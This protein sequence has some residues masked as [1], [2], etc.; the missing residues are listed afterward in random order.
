MNSSVHNANHLRNRSDANNFSYARLNNEERQDLSFDEGL[1]PNL[2]SKGISVEN[3]AGSKSCITLLP[4]FNKESIY[5]QKCL[6]SPE[7]CEYG[8]SFSLWVYF[9][10]SSFSAKE[11]LL[12][13]TP[14]NCQGYQIRIEG[15]SLI[16]QVTGRSR[17]WS[18]RVIIDKDRKYWINYGFIWASSTGQMKIYENNVLLSS[19]NSDLTLSMSPS[20]AE[21]G[22]GLMLGCTT[23]HGEPEGVV[24]NMTFYSLALWYWPVQSP[25]FLNGGLDFYLYVPVTPTISTTSAPV[26]IRSGPLYPA[27]LTEYSNSANSDNS[28]TIYKTADFYADPSTVSNTLPLTDVATNTSHILM[29]DYFLLKSAQASGKIA[30]F[31]SDTCP[32]NLTACLNGFS[33]SFWL[34][35]PEG[36]DDNKLTVFEVTK[37][38]CVT[39]FGHS[40]YIFFFGASSSSFG[41]RITS[42]VP[43]NAWINVGFVTND[44]SFSEFFAYFNGQPTQ[45]IRVV[46]VADGSP[47][48]SGIVNGDLVLGSASASNL[49]VAK[50][51]VTSLC[52]WYQKLQSTQ[53]GLLMGYTAHQQTWLQNSDYFWTTDP[54]INQD[55]KAQIDT[56]PLLLRNRFSLASL[57]VPNDANLRISGA[58]HDDTYGVPILD[59]KSSGYFMLGKRKSSKPSW[60]VL[61]WTNDCLLDPTPLSCSRNG[62][63]LSIWVKIVT[64]SQT[65]TRFLLNSGNFGQESGVFQADFRGISVFTSGSLLGVSVSTQNLQWT[66]II[67][68]TVYKLRSWHNFGITW[69][70]SEGLC[71]YIDG[72]DYGLRKTIADNVYKS[73]NA[74]PYL[75]VGRYDSDE[76][77]TWLSPN[78]A[79]QLAKSN[80]NPLK[81]PNWEMANIQLGEMAYVKKHMSYLSYVKLFRVMGNKFL[82]KNEPKFYSWLGENLLVP[83]SYQLMTSKK[84]KSRPGQVNLSPTK[85]KAEWQED[86]F[87]VRLF[88]STGLLLGPV[89]N[90]PCLNS[91]ISCGDGFFIS[92]WFSLSTTTPEGAN[93]NNFTQLLRGASGRMGLAFSPYKNS[94][95]GWYTPQ[96]TI[97]QDGSV[98]LGS[99]YWLCLYALDV[100]K[101]KRF[102]QWFHIGLNFMNQKLDLFYNGNKVKSCDRN[103]MASSEPSYEPLMRSI[104]SLNK[105]IFAPQYV[106][107]TS[108]QQ[109]NP[110]ESI[111][112]SL[113]TFKSIGIGNSVDVLQHMGLDNMQMTIF[114]NSEF[115][116]PMSGQYQM[117]NSNR[118]RLFGS[119]TQ[120]QDKNGN[121]GGALCTKNQA[122]S[123]LQLSGDPLINSGGLSNLHKMCIIDSTG[124]SSF[125]VGLTFKLMSTPTS[126][127]VLLST[128]PDDAANNTIGFRLKLDSKAQVLKAEIFSRKNYCSNQ[129]STNASVAGSIKLSQWT[130]LLVSWYSGKSPNIYSNS[131]MIA[132]TISGSCQALDSAYYNY[133]TNGLVYPNLII[134]KGADGCFSNV[135][136]QD[137]IL[138]NSTE[139][140]HNS[141]T[142]CYPKA[143]GVL[144]FLGQVED[145]ATNLSSLFVNGTGSTSRE[146]SCLFSLDCANEGLTLSFWIK[147]F[148][149]VSLSSDGITI[150]NAGGVPTHSGVRI[151]LTPNKDD[152]ESLDLRIQVCT[153]K[154]LWSLNGP[155]SIYWDQWTNVG[156]TFKSL[157]STDGSIL[158]LYINGERTY[159]TSKLKPGTSGC[160][161]ESSVQRQLVLGAADMPFDAAIYQL[162]WWNSKVV[163]CTQMRN[164][165]KLLT[166]SCDIDESVPELKICIDLNKC[167]IASG[168]ICLDPTLDNIQSMASNAAVLNS[169]DDLG[170]LV[171]S[172][173]QL[174]QNV[175]LDNSTSTKNDTLLAALVSSASIKTQ[176]EKMTLDR[177]PTVSPVELAKYIVAYVDALQ[178]PELNPLWSQ[179]R[180]LTKTTSDS[181]ISGAS[182]ILNSLLIGSCQNISFNSSHVAVASFPVFSNV[183]LPN[184]SH[185]S[186]QKILPGMKLTKQE[187]SM[188]IYNFR[189]YSSGESQVN[190]P[191]NIFLQDNDTC[192]GFSVLLLPPTNSSTDPFVAGGIPTS[193][194]DL[195]S[196]QSVAQVAYPN[197]RN[198]N[199]QHI[200]ATKPKELVISSSVI[201]IEPRRMNSTRI[202]LN[203]STT[204]I[205]FTLPLKPPNIPKAIDNYVSYYRKKWDALNISVQMQ[206]AMKNGTKID[207]DLALPVQCVFWKQHSFNST[208]VWA[209]DGCYLVRANISHVTCTC[210]H[211][212]VFAIAMEP[213][214]SIRRPLPFWELNGIFDYSQHELLRFNINMAGNSLS[215]VMTLTTIGLFVLKNCKSMHKVRYQVRINF[216]L[217]L[218]LWHILSIVTPLL[219]ADLLHCQI[220]SVVWS[221]SF[222][223]IHSWLCRESIYLFYAY[224]EGKFDNYLLNHICWGWG[225]PL[226]FT[227][228]SGAVTKLAP[229]ADDIMCWLARESPVMWATLGFVCLLIVIAFLLTSI[230]SCN[231]ETPAY[232]DPHLIL[233][234]QFQM[235]QLWK[236]VVYESV[237]FIMTCLILYTPFIYSIYIYWILAS[238]QG[239]VAVIYFAIHDEELWLM[240]F[241]KKWDRYSENDQLNSVTKKLL[242]KFVNDEEMLEVGQDEIYL[243]SIFSNKTG[244]EL[245]D[246]ENFEEPLNEIFYQR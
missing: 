26:V 116:W 191:P 17:I 12:S 56:F 40:I 11:Y 100:Y 39:I 189:P 176:L 64:V 185:L 139:L 92:G 57:Y 203:D 190:L 137:D 74:P 192:N 19:A 14:T 188:A 93:P 152:S 144:R 42:S 6:E 173:A 46:S 55:A 106:A 23:S 62:F 5:Y 206:E 127:L 195:T 66:L 194:F 171:N 78:T 41:F 125:M 147:A 8:I 222:L 186:M 15:R 67:D 111:S 229:F 25:Q 162:A 60:D 52:F 126:D 83:T 89:E 182:L 177:P 159:L 193:S 75:V 154:E 61:R 223:A 228:C 151:F 31:G 4:D 119:V 51:K 226:L 158:E 76:D 73:P 85:S 219:E 94:F 3:K 231:L 63:T 10:D 84:Y 138:Q 34:F 20:N 216:F 140:L 242:P 37:S 142:Y 114:Q 69:N 218:T 124:C 90:E 211:M 245:P 58:D 157:T 132:G 199:L 164:S 59:M 234:L 236:I 143:A 235:W 122:T 163:S 196:V 113:V 32:G 21:V 44:P 80:S 213:K 43:R 241:E 70:D 87:S 108:F 153:P 33:F 128:T 210:T 200:K 81:N 168:S 183:S 97:A 150:L 221:F 99:D 30:S 149:P 35:I 22:K 72:V 161:S 133:P 224:V 172:A 243:R 167:S 209:S 47:W 36:K 109:L 54:Y 86:T 28:S 205:N 7:K 136:T 1:T 141:T 198:L 13:S 208:G 230:T 91:S 117:M 134:G 204:W 135:Q 178:S 217:S 38:F 95:H 240:I 24:A 18:M 187:P 118:Y 120:T 96:V 227:I 2:L 9:R 170:N 104:A 65:R 71:L 184:S 181:A 107:V 239:A 166:G 237:V 179:V 148:K 115:F 155:K 129:V 68:S 79:D 146:Y 180:E 225:L 238:L 53:T 48:K 50:A 82:P 232:M 169:V 101:E 244:E 214:N 49:A 88:G 246:K 29:R 77:S 233:S 202:R 131:L 201:T 16:F 220:V 207:V 27:I 174:I 212:T 121:F 156:M 105:Y 112:V 215:L 123:Y 160:P 110:N 102:A 165:K 175:L 197:G 45:V 145:R 103:A 98:N 130:E